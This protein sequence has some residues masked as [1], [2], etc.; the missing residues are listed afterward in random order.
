MSTQPA[1]LLLAMQLSE[2]LVRDNL[3]GALIEVLSRM[4]AEERYA[5]ISGLMCRVTSL[6]VVLVGP[7]GT[8]RVLATSIEAAS[9]APVEA[10]KAAQ[11]LRDGLDQANATKREVH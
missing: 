9:H 11:V 8:R 2:H 7:E 5:A 4:P 1:N 10:V 3:Q 6:S